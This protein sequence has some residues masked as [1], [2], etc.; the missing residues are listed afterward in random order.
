VTAPGGEAVTQVDASSPVHCCALP[1]SDEELWELTAQF[2]GEGLRAGEQVVYAENRTA[3]AVLDRLVDD[4]VPVRAPLASGQLTILPTD[5]TV[6][7]AGARAADVLAA[8]EGIIDAALD[9]G[10]PGI[11]IVGETS[12]AIRNGDGSAML[13]YESRFDDLLVGRPA[14]IR[15]LYDRNRYSDADITRLRA[16][17]RHELCPAPPLYDDNLLRITHPRPSTARL[18]GEVDHSN[19]PRIRR[20]LEAVLDE[21]LRSPDSPPQVELDLA[22]LRFLD[23]AG[24]VSLVH[25]AAEFPRTHT[26]LLTGV[27]PAVMR[28]LDRCGAPFAGQLRV[29]PHPGPWE[30]GQDAGTAGDGAGGTGAGGGA[31]GEDEARPEAGD[32]G[33][34]D[35]GAG[36]DGA[37]DDGAG[38]DGG[39]GRRDPEF[40]T[41][42]V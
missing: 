28:V 23:V 31:T 11:R 34:G 27:R 2:L 9:G 36:D 12:A 35:D 24:A 5:V 22:S 1:V 4:G 42:V 29:E 15:C 10:Y 14:R 18:A 17:H 33:T 25:A 20:A 21:T 40:G 8:I 7:M 37:G 32:D 30:A 26:L 6:G 3:D 38:D 13:E 41:V 19:R 39:I 16:V